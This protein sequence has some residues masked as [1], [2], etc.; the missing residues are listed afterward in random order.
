MTVWEW[1]WIAM[2]SLAVVLVWLGA[3]H[4]ANRWWQWVPEPIGEKGLIRWLF[5]RK[6]GYRAHMPWSV[7]RSAS[8]RLT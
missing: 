2:A 4:L 5:R 8:K 1:V 3:E 6:E 7:S